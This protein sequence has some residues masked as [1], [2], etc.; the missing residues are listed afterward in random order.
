MKGLGQSLV[1]NRGTYLLP[2]T[3]RKDQLEH[4]FLSFVSFSDICQSAQVWARGGVGKKGPF[5]LFSSS[6]CYCMSLQSSSQPPF[7]ISRASK[8]LKPLAAC[9]KCAHLA[10]PTRTATANKTMLF[11]PHLVLSITHMKN[12]PVTVRQVSGFSRT[13]PLRAVPAPLITHWPNIY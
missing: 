8:T 6:Q 7:T 12:G 5:I 10:F 9:Q 1:H 11:P 13:I 4:L 2:M 3:L